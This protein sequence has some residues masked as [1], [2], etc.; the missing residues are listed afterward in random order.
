[1]RPVPFEGVQPYW[2]GKFSGAIFEGVGYQ[3]RARN[4]GVPT[5]ETTRVFQRGR[6]VLLFAA[7]I[8]L[9]RGDVNSVQSPLLLQLSLQKVEVQARRGPSVD[10]YHPGLAQPEHQSQ[11]VSLLHD[12]VVLGQARGRRFQGV[13]KGSGGQGGVANDTAAVT[14]VFGQEGAS[15]LASFS[16]VENC[17]ILICLASPHSMSRLKILHKQK[18]GNLPAHVER[19]LNKGAH[20]SRLG[21]KPS[22]KKKVY[23][24]SAGLGATACPISAEYSGSDRPVLDAVSTA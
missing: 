12:R 7:V 18:R 4:H 8:H 24:I 5:P 2:L 3:A 23:T 22:S 10:V 9:E 11:R 6:Y 13:I 20:L 16:A 19:K 17:I 1:M 15:S 21:E 14:S